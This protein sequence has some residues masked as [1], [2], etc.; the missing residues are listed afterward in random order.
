MTACPRPPVVFDLTKRGL[1]AHLQ[2]AVLDTLI[3]EQM[4]QFHARLREALGT[5]V[6]AITLGH[7]EHVRDVLVLRDELCIRVDVTMDGASA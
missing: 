6:K 2:E 3:E 1:E 5:A 4:D 7:I